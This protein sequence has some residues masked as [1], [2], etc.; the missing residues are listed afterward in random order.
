[1]KINDILDNIEGPIVFNQ[2]DDNEPF[3]LKNKEKITP[4]SIMQW[5]FNQHKAMGLEPIDN[6]PMHLKHGRMLLELYGQ[7][8]T[9]YVLTEF[10]KAVKTQHPFTLMFVINWAKGQ[11]IEQERKSKFAKKS[12]F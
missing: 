10:S 2:P 9:K 5:L 3:N 1:M 8:N 12:M 11:K 7:K 6:K 4:Y